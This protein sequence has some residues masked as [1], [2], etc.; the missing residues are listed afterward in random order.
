M[1]QVFSLTSGEMQKEGSERRKKTSSTQANSCEEVPQIVR[2]GIGN[3]ALDYETYCYH[4]W[5]ILQVL[6]VG[7]EI[8]LARTKA[9]GL[10]VDV[11]AAVAIL[12]GES[13]STFSTVAAAQRE[14]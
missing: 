11:G 9:I 1:S 12:S 5:N 10:T 14:K 7:W 4:S 13:V 6:I 8:G 3:T 2:K